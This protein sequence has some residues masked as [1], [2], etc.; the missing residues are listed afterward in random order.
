MKSLQY[1]CPLDQTTVIAILLW[2]HHWYCP[3]ENA[4]TVAI[5]EIDVDDL[6]VARHNG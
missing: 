1:A 3:V 2:D 4:A 6:A 5:A